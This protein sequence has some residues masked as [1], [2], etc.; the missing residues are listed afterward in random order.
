MPVVASDLGGISLYGWVF[1]AFFLGD[2]VGIV[3]AGQQ[4]DTHGLVRPYLMGLGLFAAGLAI[5][6]LAPS[7]PVLV[8]ARGVQGLGAGAIPAVGYVSI[9]RQYPPGLRPRMFAILSTAWVVPGI[10]GPALAGLVAAQLS[11]RAVFLGLLPLVVV[12]AV[13]TVPSLGRVVRP[14]ATV[15]PGADGANQPGPE[16]PAANQPGPELPAANQPAA[17]QPAAHRPGTEPPDSSVDVPAHGSADR[18]SGGV[19]RLVDAVRVAVGAGLVLG[20]LD[21]HQP[22]PLLVLGG[23]GSAVALPSLRRLLPEGALRGRAGLPA[24]VL[25]RGVLTFGFTGAEAFVPLMLVS[26]RGMSTA[27]AGLSLTA[28]TLTWTVGSWVQARRIASWGARRLIRMGLALVVCG[29]GLIAVA[30]G[31]GVPVW[32][33]VGA[34]GV[35][36]LGMGLSYAAITLL[37]LHQAPRNRQGEATAGLQLSDVLGTALGAG[38]GGVVLALAPSLG[39]D[40]REALILTFGIATAAVVAGLALTSRLGADAGPGRAGAPERQPAQERQAA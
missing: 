6:G 17:N 13:L 1:S 10:A 30:T 21:S 32:I 27:Q 34:W 36:G 22:V 19:A 8:V 3:A 2:L 4:A 39:W 37:V 11:W 35:A 16:L 5:G 23:V 28:A 26:L 15:V 12:A 24:A 33:G 29:I 14:A 31:P 18:S 40:E 25:L 38:V 20:A 9:A 7:M